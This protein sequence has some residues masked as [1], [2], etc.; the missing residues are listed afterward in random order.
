MKVKVSGEISERFLVDSS[1]YPTQ[2]SFLVFW[3]L[4][5]LSV[6]PNFFVFA[7]AR[8]GRR[9]NVTTATAALPTRAQIHQAM[10]RLR[11]RTATM[12]S[13]VA[14]RNPRKTRCVEQREPKSVKVPSEI[15]ISNFLILINFVVLFKRKS[16]NGIIKLINFSVFSTFRN[17]TFSLEISNCP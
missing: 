16:L 2:D 13:T 7:E 4:R 14:T 6:K 8:S 9:R 1:C 11:T 3:E 10:S 12:E 17:F 15:F 5:E